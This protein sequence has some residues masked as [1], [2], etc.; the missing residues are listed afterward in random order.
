MQ[1]YGFVK[2]LCVQFRLVFRFNT[3]L[4]VILGFFMDKKGDQDR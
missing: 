3:M 1:F 2:A 4:E